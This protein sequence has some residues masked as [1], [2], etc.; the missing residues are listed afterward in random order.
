MLEALQI[1][2]SGKKTMK[3]VEKKM[4]E[5]LAEKYI[6]PKLGHPNKL[7]KKDDKS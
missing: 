5:E 2:E 3:Q 1:V 6:Y 4:G 7:N